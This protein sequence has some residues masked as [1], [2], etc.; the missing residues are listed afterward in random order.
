MQK[1]DAVNTQRNKRLEDAGAFRAPRKDPNKLLKG[2][3]PKFEGKVHQVES[4]NAGTVKDTDGKE[5]PVKVVQPVASSS[6]DV[7]IEVG[8]DD[9]QR[10][11]EAKAFQPL[12][13]AAKARTRNRPGG[14]SLESFKQFLE[15]N[16]SYD[17][18]LARLKIRKDLGARQ[19]V[20]ASPKD[21]KLRRA[22]NRTFVEAM[23]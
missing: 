4:I 23:P 10:I 20:A 22:G 2:D 9:R 6:R 12:L 7:E 3:Q 1:N 13:Q 8:V 16:P 18:M 19:F 5:Y 15:R 14:V 21:L 17:N 11:K